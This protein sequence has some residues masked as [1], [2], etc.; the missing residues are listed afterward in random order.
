MRTADI[1]ESFAALFAIQLHLL[2]L[3]LFTPNDCSLCRAGSNTGGSS[4]AV[5]TTYI[6]VVTAADSSTSNNSSSTNNSSS[7]SSRSGSRLFMGLMDPSPRCEHLRNAAE[8][9]SAAGILM[10]STQPAAAAAAASK[11]VLKEARMDSNGAPPVLWVPQ[12]PQ[13]QQQQQQQQNSNSSSSYRANG[14]SSNGYPPSTAPMPV[15]HSPLVARHRL[16]L[17]S[18]Y[19]QQVRFCAIAV[20]L[21]VLVMFRCSVLLQEF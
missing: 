17:R 13:Q 10:T 19:A 1:T 5:C 21:H 14:P 11:A 4:S 15:L 8:N 6:P 20:H 16:K 2:A 3:Q 9:N 18:A 12:Q 7:S